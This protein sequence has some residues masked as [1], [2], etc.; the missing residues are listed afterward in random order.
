[1]IPKIFFQFWNDE[2]PL[3]IQMNLDQNKKIHKDFTYRLIND[4][5]MVDFLTRNH[6]KKIAEAYINNTIPASRSDIARLFMIWHF[7]G[8]YL[9]AAWYCQ[10]NLYK[11]LVKQNPKA[12]VILVKGIGRENFCNGCVAAVPKHPFIRKVLNKVIY[13]ILNKRYND[14]VWNCTGP[15]SYNEAYEEFENKSQI[16]GKTCWYELRAKGIIVCRKTGK[17]NEWT[18]L[19]KNGIYQ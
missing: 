9:D 4:E 1:M 17:N 2:P 6:G 14:N 15:L 7:G 18:K 19:Q 16:N 11:F 5:F 8:I 12:K 13:N 10:K 3:P